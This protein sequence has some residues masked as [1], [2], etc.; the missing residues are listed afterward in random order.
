M[1]VHAGKSSY[2]NVLTEPNLKVESVVAGLILSF[3]QM[4]SDLRNIVPTIGEVNGD[5]T[6]N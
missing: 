3:R 1:I 2:V 5:L 4:E 6:L